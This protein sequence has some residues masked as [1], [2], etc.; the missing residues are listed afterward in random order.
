[1]LFLKTLDTGRFEGRAGLYECKKVFGVD[2]I[3]VSKDYTYRTHPIQIFFKSQ[4]SY[5]EQVFIKDWFNFILNKLREEY[6]S[7]FMTTYRESTRYY[8]RK[9]LGLNQARA[10]IKTCPLNDIN[11]EERKRIHSLELWI[12]KYLARKK[13]KVKDAQKQPTLLEY[14]ASK[15]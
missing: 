9:Y 10:I 3:M 11:V 7:D 14:V 15:P 4:L 2:G 6:D 1:V 8:T 12:E 5:D 13:I